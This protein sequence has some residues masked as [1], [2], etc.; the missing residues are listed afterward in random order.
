MQ[1]IVLEILIMGQDV[2]ES[3]RTGH[4]LST[5][6]Q[7]LTDMTLK[8]QAFEVFLPVSMHAHYTHIIGE[9][10]FTLASY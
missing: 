8:M 10:V 2:K 7:I 4:I 5:C 3:S 6:Q 9:C 1:L